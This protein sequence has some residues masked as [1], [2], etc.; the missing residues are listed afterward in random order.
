M[1]ALSPESTAI[2]DAVKNQLIELH[3]TYRTL[4]DLF[5][6][7][8]EQ[9]E[10]LQ[11][12]A[13]MM[14]D[15]AYRVLLRDVVLG[16]TRLTDPLQTAGKHNLVFER[17]VNLPEVQAD[18]KIRASVEKK[19]GEVQGRSEPFR[20]H[21]DKYL[22]HLDL[23]KVI[24]PNDVVQEFPRKNV[25]ALLVAMADVYNRVVRPLLD[26]ETRFDMISIQ[27]GAPALVRAIEE[28]RFWRSLPGS[29]RS[30]LRRE[31][32]PKRPPD[33]PPAM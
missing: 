27:G 15:T 29:E 31:F 7:S 18:S 16:I 20:S 22:A 2:L 8:V 3:S 12:A 5:G 1:A 19:L 26:E 14:F 17:L 23:P 24:D 6:V 4:I 33:V 10:L 9:S 32:G 30:R 28:S 25:E 11:E 21:R 13:P